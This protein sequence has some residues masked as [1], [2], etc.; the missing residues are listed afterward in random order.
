MNNTKTRL[1]D[2]LNP[3]AKAHTLIKFFEN[4]GFR[5]EVS[6]SR[7]SQDT[8]QHIEKT[9]NHWYFNNEEITKQM[10]ARL[11]AGH[12]FTNGPR[13]TFAPRGGSTTVQL[14]KDGKVYVG[15]AHCSIMDNFCR[16][17]GIK[18]ALRRASYAEEDGV[19][20]ADQ[21]AEIVAA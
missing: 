6:H 11:L 12:N 7:Y 15:N 9:R 1:F 13:R 21:T 19:Y 3:E 2:T 16:A 4:L 10:E 8:F 17:R 5:V 20:Q 14:I 18:E